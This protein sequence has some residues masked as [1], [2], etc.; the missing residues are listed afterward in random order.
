MQ[1]YREQCKKWHSALALFLSNLHST[2]LI[3]IWN[4]VNVSYVKWEKI[5]MYKREMCW[6][7]IQTPSSL[8]PVPRVLIVVDK[9]V[10]PDEVFCLETTSR[11]CQLVPSKFNWSQTIKL[12]TFHSNYHLWSRARYH[13][14]TVIAVR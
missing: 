10:A 13:L 2:E 5:L 3:T 12:R 4:H 7:R 11:L 14:Y 6:T 9:Q 1:S 8:W